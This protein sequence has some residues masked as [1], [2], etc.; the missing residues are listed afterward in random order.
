MADADVAAS[1]M[2]YWLDV[3]CTGTNEDRQDFYR[4]FSGA[5]TETLQKVREAAAAYLPEG[6]IPEKSAV[7]VRA[8]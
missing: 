1:R 4:Y 2:D 3:L 5:L 8:R 7:H 6:S